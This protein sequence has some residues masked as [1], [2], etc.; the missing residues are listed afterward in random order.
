MGPD[1]RHGH[2]GQLLIPGSTF[3]TARLIDNGRWFL[4]G[5]AEWPGVVPADAGIG[6]LNELAAMYSAA[7]PEMREIAA[8]VRDVVMGQASPR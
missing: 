8:S 6:N 3:H 5:S 7:A 1:L 2:Q 4:G